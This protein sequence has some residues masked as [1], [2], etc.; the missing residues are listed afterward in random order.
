MKD[1]ES[2][3]LL[4]SEPVYVEGTS[5][6]IEVEVAFTYTSTYQEQINAFCNRINVVD[7]GTLVTGFKNA[8]T[9]IVLLDKL[10]SD[11]YHA[12]SIQDMT[13]YLN[14]EFAEL[15]KKCK[16]HNI[17]TAVETTMALHVPRLKELCEVVDLFLIDF[18]I[19]DDS[20]S[21]EILHLNIEK[22]KENI[23]ISLTAMTLLF[24]LL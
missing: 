12:Y 21:K 23:Y 3:K 22:L 18:K 6:D 20:K 13:N 16:E 19:F 5:G 8:L 10:L 2:T 11:R 1:S 17:H 24:L 14:K 9:R 7:G 4:L 15:L